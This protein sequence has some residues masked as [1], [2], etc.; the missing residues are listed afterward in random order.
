M[1]VRLCLR[2]LQ[3][4]TKET[5]KYTQKAAAQFTVKIKHENK[6]PSESLYCLRILFILCLRKKNKK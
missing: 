2:K 5:R 4:A 3:L 6:P 1:S